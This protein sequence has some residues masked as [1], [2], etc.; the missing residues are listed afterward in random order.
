VQSGQ[1]NVVA[2]CL[3][4]DTFPV[5]IMFYYAGSG[6]LHTLLHYFETRGIERRRNEE[7]DPNLWR[8]IFLLPLI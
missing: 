4:G 3:R 6:W 2:G 7:D 1:E 5:L 8:G